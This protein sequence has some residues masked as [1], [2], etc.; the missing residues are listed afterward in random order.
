MNSG[1]SYPSIQPSG[2]ESIFLRTEKQLK[3]VLEWLGIYAVQ[4]HDMVERRAATKLT[5]EVIDS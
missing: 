4:V 2:V 1:P 3:R 5:K